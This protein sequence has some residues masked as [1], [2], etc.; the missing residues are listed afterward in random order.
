V[1]E[2]VMVIALMA[3]LS[4][5]GTMV[6]AYAGNQFGSGS[7]KAAATAGGAVACSITRSAVS[8]RLNQRG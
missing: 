8:D 2:I 3:M 4:A 7:G 5:C 1:K 6:G